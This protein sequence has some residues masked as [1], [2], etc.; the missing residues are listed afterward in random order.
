MILL[1]F[2]LAT[3]TTNQSSKQLNIVQLCPHLEDKV[4]SLVTFPLGEGLIFPAGKAYQ[5]IRSLYNTRAQSTNC[6]SSEDWPQ[7]VTA[8]RWRSVTKLCLHPP[9]IACYYLHTIILIKVLWSHVSLFIKIK[10]EI[11]TQWFLLNYLFFFKL[12][13][14]YQAICRNCKNCVIF[15]SLVTCKYDMTLCPVSFTT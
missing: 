12:C 13:A 4:Q 9:W 5:E 11:L 3:N 1:I 14:P 7:M 8:N 6:A 15:I 10:A 2:L